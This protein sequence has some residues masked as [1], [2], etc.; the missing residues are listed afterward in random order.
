MLVWWSSHCLWTIATLKAFPP[1]PFMFWIMNTNLL[2]NSN[3]STL[4]SMYILEMIVCCVPFHS[5]ARLPTVPNYLNDDMVDW[6]WVQQFDTSTSDR[7]FLYKKD[8][9]GQEKEHTIQCSVYYPDNRANNWY[10]SS[11]NTNQFAWWFW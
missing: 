2:G 6:E 3:F 5:F 7:S 9:K 8:S 11:S 1:L 10:F 4:D